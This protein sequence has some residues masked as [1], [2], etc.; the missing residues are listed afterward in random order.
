[1]IIDQFIASGETKWLRQT[2]LTLLLPHGYDG[3]GPEHSSA[4]VERFLQLVD[5]DPFT[6]P[7]DIGTDR[8]RQ[9]QNCNM[10]VVIP[11]TPANLFHMLR[12][13]VH[14]QFRK[15][16][17]C[18]SPKNLLRLPACVSPLSAFDESNAEGAMFQRVIGEVDASIKPF[19][20]KRLLFC[21]G[22]IYYELVEERDRRRK[23]GSGGDVAIVRVEQ[24]APFPFDLIAQ[25]GAK[26]P[27]ARP[28]W[29]QEEPLNAGCY[30]FAA[31]HFQTALNRLPKYIGRPSSAATATGSAAKH[32]VEQKKVVQDAF[33]L[34]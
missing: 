18:I 24:M 21:S 1:V 17:I 13:Q 27:N 12:R 26:Y 28:F 15:P 11:S 3:Q 8:D 30:S 6:I 23:E 22:K 7:A 9:I 14:R 4:R 2:N 32:A 5:S 34:Q 29:V 33:T 25:Q 16:L 20:V 19:D 10:Q 31:F